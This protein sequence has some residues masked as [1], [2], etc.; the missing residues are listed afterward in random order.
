LS[1][2]NVFYQTYKY[3]TDPIIGFIYFYPQESVGSVVDLDLQVEKGIK[4][5]EWFGN[6]KEFMHFH[7]QA[8]L[9]LMCILSIYN[10]K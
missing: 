7:V 10:A 9:I 1:V 6:K 3:R 8:V 5:Y 2:Y 4:V